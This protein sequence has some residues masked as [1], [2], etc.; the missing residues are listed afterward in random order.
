MV[1]IANTALANTAMAQSNKFI[2]QMHSSQHLTVR[3]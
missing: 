1:F 3:L 2:M